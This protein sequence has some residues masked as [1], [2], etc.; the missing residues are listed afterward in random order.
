[1]SICYQTV[2]SKLKK[3]SNTIKSK[4]VFF[5]FFFRFYK[6]YKRDKTQMVFETHFM[7]YHLLSHLIG[8]NIDKALSKKEQKLSW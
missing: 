7:I 2:F 1:M 4:Y 5:F 6:I 3:F 8:I